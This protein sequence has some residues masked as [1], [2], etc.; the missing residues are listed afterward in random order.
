MKAEAVDHF[1]PPAI[2]APCRVPSLRVV[3]FIEDKRVP[4]EDGVPAH[5]E[6]EED[7]TFS[8]EILDCEGQVVDRREASVEE[9]LSNGLKGYASKI[10]AE[11]FASAKNG[12]S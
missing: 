9:H 4:E 11:L 8:Y 2:K 12:I 7:N 1:G 3:L 10:V 6:P 5:L